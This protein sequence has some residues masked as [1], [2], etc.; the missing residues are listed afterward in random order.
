MR[1]MCFRARFNEVLPS[2]ALV[3]ELTYHALILST[4]LRISAQTSLRTK[5]TKTKRRHRQAVR[6]PLSAQ[7]TTRRLIA[8]TYQTRP[9]MTNPVSRPPLRCLSTNAMAM[10]RVQP[11]QHPGGTLFQINQEVYPR[12]SPPDPQPSTTQLQRL[13][14]LHSAPRLLTLR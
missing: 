6:A 14:R 3:F 2:G 9:P 11:N 8:L 5:R 4:S 13:H 10:E 12:M 7:R 1:A